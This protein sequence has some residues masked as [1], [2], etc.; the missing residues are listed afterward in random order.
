VAPNYL[1]HALVKF[2]DKLQPFDMILAWIYLGTKQPDTPDLVT[3][4]LSAQARKS[5]SSHTK[6]TKHRWG[7]ISYIVILPKYMKIWSL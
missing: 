5:L 4:Q 7:N 2:G 6:T 1:R 3:R